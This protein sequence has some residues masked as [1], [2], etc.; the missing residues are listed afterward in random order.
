VLVVYAAVVTVL[1]FLLQTT[2]VD[3]SRAA[4]SKASMDPLSGVFQISFSR[5]LY[6]CVRIL[7][8]IV[9]MCITAAC[10]T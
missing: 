9:T 7:V 10:Q 5:R 2:I 1:T 3:Q 6:I 4:G 8:V